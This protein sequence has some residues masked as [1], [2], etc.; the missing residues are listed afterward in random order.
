M[1]QEYDV[2]IK[3]IVTKTIRVTA[4]S[5]DAATEEAHSLFT[6]APEADEA[7]RYEEQTVSCKKVP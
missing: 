5:D 6:V 7:E 2:T 4:K 1:D 3:G